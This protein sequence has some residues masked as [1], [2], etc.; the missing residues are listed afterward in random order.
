MRRIK[1]TDLEIDE[2]SADCS[3]VLAGDKANPYPGM[4]YTEGVDNCLRWLLGDQ[5]EHPMK[6]SEA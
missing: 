1:R 4:S 3:E 5:D 6:D 2:L